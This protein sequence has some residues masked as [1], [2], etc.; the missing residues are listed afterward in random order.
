MNMK[1][2]NLIPNYEVYAVRYAAHDRTR[3]DNFI[4]SSDPHDEAMPMDYYVW[5][6]K[7]NGNVWLVDTGF[8]AEMASREGVPNFV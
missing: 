7:G 2:E 5:V 6:I 3:R 8:N 1:I 4:A